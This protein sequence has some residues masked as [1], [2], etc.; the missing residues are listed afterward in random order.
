M[1][2][3][4][5]EP[6]GSM[7]NDASLA[8]LSSKP[9]MPFEYFKQLFAQ[10][11]NP[12]IDPI[13][14]SFVMTLR[15]PVGPELNVFESTDKHCKRLIIDTPILTEDEIALLKNVHPADNSN[16][17]WKSMTL[18]CSFKAYA[19]KQA[20]I[21]R[22]DEL[23]TAAENAIEKKNT[24]IIVLSDKKANDKFCAIPSLI[25]IGAIHHHLVAKQL[26]S[27]VAIFLECGDAK[28]VHDF[29]TLLGYGADGVC[30]YSV[31]NTISKL[32]YEQNT[33]MLSVS[34]EEAIKN[35]ISAI[36]KGLLKVC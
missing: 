24:P 8:V 18:D 12:P 15:C 25:A 31:Y 20:M 14:E 23:C 3:T 35:Y 17:G 16:R 4:G 2:L 10:V 13:R 6:L 9:K 33:E 36:S 11:T 7:G 34:K 27:K 30:P 29:S 26:R 32:Q 19:G 28:E 21:D 22:I 1:F 5:K